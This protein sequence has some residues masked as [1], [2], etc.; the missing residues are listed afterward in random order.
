MLATV[1]RLTEGE[2]QQILSEGYRAIDQIIQHLSDDRALV[3]NQHWELV[4]FMITSLPPVPHYLLGQEEVPED[5]ALLGGE[6]TT[7]PDAAAPARIIAPARVHEI[8]AELSEIPSKI[9]AYREG[10]VDF[11]DDVQDGEYGYFDPSIDT[12]EA[13]LELLEPKL[14]DLI[15]LYQDAS[16]ASDA[17]FIYAQ[18]SV[19]LAAE[20]LE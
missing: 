2:Y 3:L 18:R 14:I 11:W 1:Y 6:P 8:A 15:K 13:Y 17:I 10:F 16:Q 20:H 7:W 12:P 19:D 4:S 9:E 5:E